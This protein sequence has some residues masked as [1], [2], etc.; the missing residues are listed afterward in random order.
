MWSRKIIQS[1]NP[2]KKSNRRSRF[3]ALPHLKGVANFCTTAPFDGRR[4]AR[5]EASRSRGE[6]TATANIQ[7][8]VEIAL[9][10]R[11]GAFIAQHSLGEI[12]GGRLTMS[13]W[14]LESV[15]HHAW[16]RRLDAAITCRGR[17]RSANIQY[18]ASGAHR[19]HQSPNS[20]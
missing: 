7:P 17:L 1:D 15:F 9:I 16:E 13:Y 5:G 8:L 19:Q 12:P 11:G 2:R 18:E 20:G 3:I 14:R 4:V 10:L 6:L